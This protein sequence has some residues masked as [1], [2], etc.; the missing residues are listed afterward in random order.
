VT[1]DGDIVPLASC[2]NAVFRF[3]PIAVT[4]DDG[5]HTDRKVS[6]A[7]TLPRRYIFEITDETL[8]Q[9]ALTKALGSLL[10]SL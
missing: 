2:P 5:G 8:Y 3:V 9:D 4:C 7:N 1:P 10:N 6:Q